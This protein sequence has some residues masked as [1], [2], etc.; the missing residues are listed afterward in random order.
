[1]ASSSSSSVVFSSAT[2][3]TSD[4]VS[5]VRLSSPSTASI[6]TSLLHAIT[7]LKPLPTSSHL[8]IHRSSSSDLSSTSSGIDLS[9][10][11]LSPSPDIPTPTSLTASLESVASTLPRY[12]I[13]GGVILAVVIFIGILSFWWKRRLRRIRH[14]DEEDHFCF[15]KRRQE[16]LNSSTPPS[17]SPTPKRPQRMAGTSSSEALTA[18][19]RPKHRSRAPSV[20]PPPMAKSPFS[21]S[22]P[23]VVISQASD[24]TLHLDT[25]P[26]PTSPASPTSPLLSNDPSA[27]LCPPSRQ[28]RQS[29]ATSQ[30]DVESTRLSH[31]EKD[32]AE[33]LEYLQRDEKRH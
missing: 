28:I 20:P 16:R 26:S 9:S 19:Q 12:L 7:T 14:F 3:L 17:H 33:L 8:P 15:E 29:T 22:P 4:P 11:L 24:S 30:L 6:T 1:M 21:D 25:Q 13:A 23:Y 2:S 5:S 27:P 31:V 10:T 32:Q 18:Q